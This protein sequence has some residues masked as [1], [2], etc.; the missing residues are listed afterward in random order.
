MSRPDRADSLSSLATSDDPASF[1]HRLSE[2]D[3]K[4][5]AH[6]IPLLPERLFLQTLGVDTQTSYSQDMTWVAE[7][8]EQH[9]M[10]LA[11]EYFL[12]E[13][14]AAGNMVARGKL[15]GGVCYDDDWSRCACW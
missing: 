4:R 3:I 14:S 5:D 2:A 12:G 9:K 11:K 10:M 13:C 1:V 7:H 8:L 6:H 15:H